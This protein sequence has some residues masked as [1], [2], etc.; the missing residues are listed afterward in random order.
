M[1]EAVLCTALFVMMVISWTV[2]PSGPDA[3]VDT[4]VGD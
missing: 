1:V 4:S 2:L 3:P